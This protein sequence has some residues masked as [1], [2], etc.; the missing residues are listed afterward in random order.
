MGYIDLIESGVLVLKDYCMLKIEEQGYIVFLDSRNVTRNSFKKL[1]DISKNLEKKH[2]IVLLNK[3][4]RVLNHEQLL[5]IT[6][7]D[8]NGS[9]KMNPRN[10][11]D[12]SL[13]LPIISLLLS[14]IIS[15][16]SYFL[17]FYLMNKKFARTNKKKDNQLDKINENIALK[18]KAKSEEEPF[19]NPKV[20]VT[21][22]VKEKPFNK[23]LQA[24]SDHRK[25]MTRKTSRKIIVLE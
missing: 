4:V 20:I 17:S 13:T 11:I 1:C 9:I 5:S 21:D 24:D 25:K 23:T 15:I 12:H 10:Q 18:E 6:N 14:I 3:A 22:E 8:V 16:S 2:D 7:I 19:S